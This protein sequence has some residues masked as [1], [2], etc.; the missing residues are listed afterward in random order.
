MHPEKGLYLSHIGQSLFRH[1]IRPIPVTAPIPVRLSIMSSVHHQLTLQILV[2]RHINTWVRLEE[3][4]RPQR[5]GVDLHWHHRPV[6]HSWVMRESK[7]APHHNVFI[8]DIV[9]PCHG[10]RYAADFLAGLHRVA[11]CSVELIVPVLGHPDV[12]VGE[13]RALRLD[14]G[15]V[16]EEELRRWGREFEADWFTRDGVR[17]VFVDDLEHAVGLGLCVGEARTLKRC[18]AD[19]VVVS[20]WVCLWVHRDGKRVFLD[21]SVAVAVDGRV[22]ADGEDV[23]MVLSQHTW[24]DDV[25]VVGLFAWVDV[26]DGDDAC[27][28]GLNVDA[29]GL[30]ELVGEDVFVVG[31]AV[32]LLV[33][34]FGWM[35]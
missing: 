23:L 11:T 22:D 8:P 16:G 10:V 29:T 12:V 20:A 9:L 2:A 15:R 5:H 3:I 33:H 31:E 14:R 18:T 13:S 24:A 6:L 7:H 34:L 30:V 21:N 4:T 35:S 27:G 32:D 28:A 19:F 26:D 17:L 25:A 1:S